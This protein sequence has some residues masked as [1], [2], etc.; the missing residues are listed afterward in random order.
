LGEADDE[1]ASRPERPVG[2]QNSAAFLDL[3]VYA[4]R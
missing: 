1:S 3:G 2:F 4:A